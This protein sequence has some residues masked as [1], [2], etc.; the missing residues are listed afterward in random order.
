MLAVL[1]KNRTRAAYGAAFVF[2]ALVYAARFDTYATSGQAFY[3]FGLVLAAAVA[4]AAGGAALQRFYAARRDSY[5]LIS[6]GLWVAAALHLVHFAAYAGVLGAAGAP[7]AAAAVQRGALLPALFF[8]FFLVLSLLAS[9]QSRPSSAEPAGVFLAAATLAFIVS[10]AALVFPAPPPDAVAWVW[11]Q[12]L[13]PLA[14]QPELLLAAALALGGIGGLLRGGRWRAGLFSRWLLLAFIVT[15]AA[16]ARFPL[17]YAWPLE[18]LLLLGQGLVVAG[19]GCVFVG[20]MTGARARKTA[21][22]PKTKTTQ[23]AAASAAPVPTVDEAPPVSG[24]ERALHDLQASHRALRNATDG[25]LL[26]VRADGT[27]ADWKPAADFG[28][29]ALPSDLLGK[30]I[31]AVLPSDQAAAILAAVGRVLQ[32]GKTER[33]EYTA[34]DGSAALGVTVTRRAAGEAVCVIHNQT[35]QARALQ[36][37]ELQRRAAESLRRVTGDWL[38]QMTRA[39]AIQDLQPPAGAET[40]TYADVFA[41]KH[42]QEVFQGD[43]VAP[44]LAAAAAA[45]A[46]DAVQEFSFVRGSGQA[47]A[48]RVAPCAADA[49]LCRLRDVSELEEAAAQLQESEDENQELRGHLERLQ[50]EQ[51]A[52]LESAEQTGRALR[53]LLPDLLLR[54]RADGTILECKPAESFGPRDGESIVDAKA[55]EVLPVDLAS[56]I[57]AAI[58]RARGEGQPQRFACHPV[59][60]QALAGGVAALA[61]DQFLCLVRDLTQQKQMETALAQQA[62]ILAQEMQAKLEAA[63]LKSLRAENDA[64]RARLLHVAQLA[65][66]S[67]PAAAPTT[68][69]A[70]GTTAAADEAPSPT[71]AAA[72]SSPPTGA[73][74]ALSPAAPEPQSA[75]PAPPGARTEPDSAAAGPDAAQVSDLPANGD[76][77]RAGNTAAGRDDAP[78]N[79]ASGATVEAAPRAG[80]A[81]AAPPASLPAPHT[82][83]NGQAERGAAVNGRPTKEVRLS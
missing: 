62:A 51:A 33:L 40:A 34:A 57:M 32:G 45:L 30:H 47:L 78:Q 43:D 81:V 65:L 18:A 83:A 2:L 11:G 4:L 10:V 76:A 15:L 63:S 58:E 22:A 7:L 16:L 61:A 38:I 50:G 37:L 20:T 54:V 44:L 67:G 49:V 27:L 13:P 79:S 42:V 72:A 71:Q 26:C 25:L 6:A 1:R 75:P 60:G 17:L 24:P 36:E 53:S 5:L 68:E 8:S 3:A 48:V 66:E 70:T 14:A 9:R 56:Q 31:A 69:S 21:A 59:G 28:P 41:G 46:G 73:P 12:P 19:Y 55:R 77:P 39:G 80:T 29:T 23:P 82:T 35:A 74:P 64:L 52:A